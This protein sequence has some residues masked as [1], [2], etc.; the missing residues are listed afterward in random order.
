MKKLFSM[1]KEEIYFRIKRMLIIIL[2][3]M[4]IISFIAIINLNAKLEDNIQ[5]TNILMEYI[6]R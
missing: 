5:A 3:S 2:I 4:V 6:T 1:P